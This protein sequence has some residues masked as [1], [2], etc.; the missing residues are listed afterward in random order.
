MMYSA[1]IMAGG[2]G[3][4][5]WPASRKSNPKQFLKLTGGKTMIR[6]TA[7][8]VSLAVNTGRIFV[9]TTAGLA[10]R[11]AEEIGFLPRENIIVEP[12]GRN[13][14]PCVALA[15]TAVRS[16]Y[17]PEE[18][19]AVLPADHRI[20]DREQYLGVLKSVLN[21]MKKSPSGVATFGIRP[22]RPETGYGYIETGEIV[23]RE[24]G[25]EI[26]RGVRF[27]EKPEAGTARRY[28]ESGG[29]LWNSG[30]F[31]LKAGTFFDLCA[32]HLPE[33]HAEI[34]LLEK[35]LNRVDRLKEIYSRLP[36]VSF[37]KGIMEKLDSFVVAPGDFGWD[38]LG[39]WLALE[40]S[41]PRDSGGNL[42]VGDFIGVD[43]ENPI[44]FSD[45]ARAVAAVG[46]KDLIV[47]VRDDVVMVCPRD[48]SQ[49]VRKLVEE[50]R[51]RGRDDLI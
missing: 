45:G 3:T 17:G 25:V 49:L 31:V 10:H 36:A 32:A 48:G 4:R 22:S 14:A 5:F 37:D 34:S 30:M 13:T 28:V 43:V 33:V 27:V 41:L 29:Y 8:R 21:Y 15:M 47:V 11:V 18:V 6:E 2:E 23:H 1:V 7:D 35:N 9:V 16:R 24:G 19:V 51:R 26:L 12:E 39:S 44:V 20:G 50:V 42:V 46:I 38:D 40:K